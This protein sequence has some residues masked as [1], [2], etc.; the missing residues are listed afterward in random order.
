MKRSIVI[1]LVFIA[2]AGLAETAQAKGDDFG[3]VVKSGST[4]IQLF[5][6]FFV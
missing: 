6:R 3:A 5:T 4:D 2:L 1:S